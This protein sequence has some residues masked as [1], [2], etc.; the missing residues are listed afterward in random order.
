MAHALTF[1]HKTEKTFDNHIWCSVVVPAAEVLG[2]VRL[3]VCCLEQF[4]KLLLL[5]LL[6]IRVF[7]CFAEQ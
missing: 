3:L 5:A 4:D 6:I 2:V 7:A 1:T